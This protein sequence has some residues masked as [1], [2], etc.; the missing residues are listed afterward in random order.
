ME[1]RH[2]NRFDNASRCVDTFIA[3]GPDVN[4]SPCTGNCQTMKIAH[5]DC[6]SGISGDMIL[7]ALLDLGL[8]EDH[9]RRE[10][11]KTGL[12][13]YSL[14]VRRESRGAISGL[15]FRVEHG[16]Q[17]SRAFA[18]IR[19]IIEQSGLSP[20]VREK[21]LE[22][23]KRLA[24][25]EAHVHRVPVERVHFHEVGAVDS[26]VDVVGAAIG[27]EYLRVDRVCSSPLPLGGGW[28]KTD[29]GLLPVP[30]PATILLLKDVPVY[31]N[32]E[33]RELVTPTGAAVLTV[34]AQSFG[35][36]PPMRLQAVGY[37][38]GSHP[39][40]D[41]PNVLRIFMG[42]AREDH[43][44][45]KELLLAET[46][47]DDMNPEFYDHVFERLFALGALDVHAVPVH[48]KKNR[49][50]ILLRVLFDPVLRDNVL[51]TIFRETTTLGVR[52]MPM[53]RFEL[54]RRILEV[55][56][57]YGSCRVKEGHIQ[58]ES[59]RVAP[60]YEDCKRIADACGKPLRTIYDEVL[61]CARSVPHRDR[62]Q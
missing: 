25:A 33:K 11:V 14:E 19:N 42:T 16:V 55:Q 12:S 53:R 44:E 29:H 43:L 45:N 20:Y 57:P 40:S 48:M 9:L 46:N 61:A 26:I 60:E 58:G 4:R 1:R 50:G 41:P 39:A 59:F 5:F 31:D 28:V 62:S 32:G 36:P 24:V 2:P 47:I 23:F 15:R 3:P 17:P 18:D 8:P 7:G 10:L 13:G 34:F 54:D 27:M 49:P 51:E 38:V 56:T 30:A 6:F 37:G 35:S 22:V 52:V 21:A